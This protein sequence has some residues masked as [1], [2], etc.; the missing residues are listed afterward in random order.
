MATR[1]SDREPSY[2]VGSLGP[3]ADVEGHIESISEIWT[4]PLLAV[5]PTASCDWAPLVRSMFVELYSVDRF[6]LTCLHIV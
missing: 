4:R 2:H 1:N 5:P 6:S 3:I